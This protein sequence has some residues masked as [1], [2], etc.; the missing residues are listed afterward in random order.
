MGG[1]IPTNGVVQPARWTPV[2]TERAG[3]RETALQR[4]RRPGPRAVGERDRGLLAVV[5]LVVVWCAVMYLQVWRRHDRFG[6][7][8]NDLGFH[9]NYVWLIARGEFFS[10]V[11]GLPAYGHNATFGYFLL[12]PFSWIGMAG[13]QWLNLFNTVAVGL[14]AVPLY[15]LARDRF[16]DAWTALPFAALWLLHPVVQGNVWETFHPDAIAMAP[17]LAAY[18]AASRG[19]WRAFW[20]FAAL[21]LIWKSDVAL[22]VLVLG[23]IVAVKWHR[24][25]GLAAVGVGALW[26]AVTVGW[27]IPHFAGGETVFGELYGDLGDNPLQ[28]AGTAVTDP[29]DVVERVVDNRPVRYSR[30]LLAPYAFVPV[31][32]GA[33][34]AIGLPQAVVNLLS[35]RVFTFE[36]RDNPH[37]QAVPMV[38]MALAL[39]EGAAFIRR[40]WGE[41]WR[42]RA[43]GAALAG[44]L[45]AT[46]AWGSLPPFT[47][48][49]DHY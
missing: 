5:V 7:F 32:G 48:Q 9:D 47:T 14:G 30:D 34:L 13:P 23:V 12:A 1:S 40:R 8:D 15:L 20:L 4:L 21:A 42:G 43:V 6:T 24:R 25:V 46:V 22:A 35:E 18:L 11:L 16:D 3:T 2:A 38:A 17:L 29:S 49:F 33:P 37:Y 44:S 31:V 28:V 19:R 39:V 26:F 10:S 45:A 27:M 41:A 36:W